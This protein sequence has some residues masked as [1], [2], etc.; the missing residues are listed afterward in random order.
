[1]SRQRV[2]RWAQ[3][4]VAAGA[5]LLVCWHLAAL[6]GAPRRA[7]VA[8]AL[9]GFVF[10]VVFG[11]AYSLVPSYFDRQL[12]TAWVPAVQ[13]PLTLAGTVLLAAGAWAGPGWAPARVGVTPTLAADLGGVLWALG[14]AVA[15]AGLAWTLRDNLTGAET[16]TGGVN[17]DRRSVD[18]VANAAVPFVLLYVLGGAYALAAPGLGLPSPVDGYPPRASHLLAAG[19]AALLLFAVGF[20]LLPRFAV[21]EPPRGAAYA[22]LPAGVVAPAL[23]AVGLPAGGLLHAGAGLEAVAVVGFAATV[24]AL[25]RRTDR[26]RVGFPA[27]LAGATAGVAAVALGLWMAVEGAVIGPARAHLRLNLLGLLGLHVVGAAYQFYPPAVG[28]HRLADDR[29]ALASIG[30]LAGGLAVQ[31]GGLLAGRRAVVAA[32]EALGLAGAALFALLVVGLLL[33]RGEL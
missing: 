7:L 10:H 22:V 24:A 3:R 20:R 16:A 12:E 2:T 1:M 32:G 4:S 18:R 28:S 8:L 31:T 9:E 29:T 11:K 26:D 5:A 6:A 30:A 19:G 25:Y 33:E 23:L 21:A 13:V 14:A 15:V 17:A 27:L